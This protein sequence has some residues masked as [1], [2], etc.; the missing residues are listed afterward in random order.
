MDIENRIKETNCDIKKL[1]KSTEASKL[2]LIYK[3][4]T[5][6]KESHTLCIFSGTV[7]YKYEEKDR[8]NNVKVNLYNTT[9]IDEVKGLE[10]EIVFR[11]KVKDKANEFYYVE[12]SPDIEITYSFDHKPYN[13][14]KAHK[15]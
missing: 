4:L 13:S 6:F 3:L 7:I 10:N 1:E 2:A 8:A 14:P 9:I 15:L 5:D 12:L 11:L